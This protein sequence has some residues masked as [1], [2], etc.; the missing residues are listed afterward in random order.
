MSAMALSVVSSMPRLNPAPPPPPKPPPPTAATAA[1]ARLAAD[2]RLPADGALGPR[3]VGP[4]PD[5]V[6]AQSPRGRLRGG[7][8][9]QR[10]GVARAVG[11][12]DDDGRRIGA[13]RAPATARRRA[14][15][16]AST[17]RGT[18]GIDLGDR[19]DRLEDAAADRGPPAR[20]SG[21]RRRRAAPRGRWSA[22]GR[23]RRSRRTRRSRSGWSSPAAAMNCEAAA[24]AASS[25][26]GA[27]SVAHM[28]RDT[29]RAR[30]TVVWPAGTLTMAA[31]R[32]MA[33]T[34]LA[35]ARTNSANGRW[36]RIR[37]ERGCATRTS[38]R[39]E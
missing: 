39:L 23:S 4:E 18:P 6:D 31:G 32:A 10:T 1:A 22:P 33:R 8:E 27:M 3:V 9:R 2:Q 11:Q 14:R 12:Q 20:S 34:R 37:D 29:S 38:D 35:S 26:L 7:V 19:V 16:P 24:S 28:L 13:V 5:G 17:L 15:R 25:R 36:R 30:I 21:W